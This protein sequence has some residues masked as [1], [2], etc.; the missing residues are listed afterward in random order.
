M[1]APAINLNRA[2]LDLLDAI[3]RGHVD[4]TFEGKIVRHLRGRL[5]R[6]CDVEV[7]R[8]VD[9]GWVELGADGVYGL[10]DVGRVGRDGA[11]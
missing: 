1:N 9:A 6:R 11:R 10:T 3:A 2:R 4:R 8:F 7:R 5:N